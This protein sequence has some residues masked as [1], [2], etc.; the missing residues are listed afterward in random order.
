MPGMSGSRQGAGAVGAAAIQRGGLRV[1][2]EGTSME[3][4]ADY[5]TNKQTKK[6]ISKSLVRLVLCDAT[7]TGPRPNSRWSL[8]VTL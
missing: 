7:S 6:H 4:S 5:E 8:Q 1:C 2:I 3:P